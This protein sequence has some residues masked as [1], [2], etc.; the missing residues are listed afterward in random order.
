MAFKQKPSKGL[1]TIVYC[2]PKGYPSESHPTCCL[3]GKYFKHTR[4]H[5]TVDIENNEIRV[6]CYYCENCNIVLTTCAQCSFFTINKDCKTDERTENLLLVVA[7][8]PVDAFNRLR[9]HRVDFDSARDYFEYKLDMN[10][11]H[12]KR[13][14]AHPICLP[15]NVCSKK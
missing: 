4:R 13:I 3:C 12:V 14:Y 2:N 7:Y 1:S 10:V 15:C 6:F 9:G 5:R 8:A 11:T